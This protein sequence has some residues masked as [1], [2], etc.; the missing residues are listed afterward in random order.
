MRTL[1]NLQ[2][3]FMCETCDPDSK[4]F[5]DLL[6]GFIRLD[7][8]SCTQINESCLDSTKRNIDYIYP[9]LKVVEP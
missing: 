8:K 2:E 4:G 7:P 1:N 6:S 9:Y 5:L 3:V